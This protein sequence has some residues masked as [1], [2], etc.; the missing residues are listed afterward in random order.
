MV[1]GLTRDGAGGSWPL[2]RGDGL[3]P[4]MIKVSRKISREQEAVH[5]SFA[6]P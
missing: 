5:A 2:I 4:G 3:L 6:C 1:S